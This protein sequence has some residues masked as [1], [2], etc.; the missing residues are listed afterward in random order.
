MTT[1]PTSLRRNATPPEGTAP[2]SGA[3][4]EPGRIAR[5]VAFVRA[6][7]ALVW[8]GVLVVAVGDDVPTTASTL[9][10]LV[11]VLLTAYPVIDVVSSVVEGGMLRVS[12]VVS[13]VAAV[14]LGVAAFG[15]DAGEVLVVFG[16]WAVVSG[17]LQL[18]VAVRRGRQ[19][20]MVISGGLSAVA[21]VSFAVASGKEDANL[22]M[23]AGY[24]AVGAI[25]YVVWAVRDRARRG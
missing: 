18:G 15:G 7:A 1:Q 21:G 17:G 13:A 9:P 20:P 23:L 8:A 16:V 22:R 14:A 5:R 2:G 10:T 4:A 11:A 3:G 19:V 6:V 25:L 24:A 12:G